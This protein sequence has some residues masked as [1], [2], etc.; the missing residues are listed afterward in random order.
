MLE[1]IRQPGTTAAS[2]TRDLDLTEPAAR[3]CTGRTAP[4]CLP[5][6]L[7]IRRLGATSSQHRAVGSNDGF[8][9]STAAL[10]A[11][12]GAHRMP[13]RWGYPLMTPNNAAAASCNAG[14]WTIVSST[15]IAMGDCRT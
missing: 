4:R 8:D 7:H 12:R 11:A 2:V 9:A 14:M 15:S 1:L 10:L 6:A 13:G 3:P 5:R